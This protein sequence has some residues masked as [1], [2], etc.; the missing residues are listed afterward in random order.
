MPLWTTGTTRRCPHTTVW[1]TLYR[2]DA[3]L[4]WTS[5]DCGSKWGNMFV[6]CKWSG[7]LDQLQ[8]CAMFVDPM[9]DKSFRTSTGE[10][11]TEKHNPQASP[12][13]PPL[14]LCG[15]VRETNN[16]VPQRPSAIVV[17]G[18]KGALGK[19]E[20]RGEFGFRVAFPSWTVCGKTSQ[21]PQTRHSFTPRHYIKAG[22]TLRTGGRRT[23]RG[24]FQTE[25]KE[26]GGHRKV[27]A[28]QQ[29]GPDASHFSCTT[30]HTAK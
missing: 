3:R 16:A 15:C 30:M 2:V 21:G 28:Q 11:K 24:T 22:Q 8:C 4:G 27:W 19:E 17:W 23:H 25:K 12:S 26:G 1:E 9:C 5:E 13:P 29:S 18:V 14:C 6:L 7:D 20:G 10:W